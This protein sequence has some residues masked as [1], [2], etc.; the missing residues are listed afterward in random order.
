MAPLRFLLRPFPN[1]ALAAACVF[2]CDSSGSATAPAGTGKELSPGSYFI[3]DFASVEEYFVIQPGH[4]WEFV[5]YGY[6][7]DPKTLCQVARR[8]GVYSSTDST[9]TLIT[10]GWSGWIEKC[11]MTKADFDA[12]PF[13]PPAVP[14]GEAARIRK[15]TADGFEAESLLPGKPAGWMS[16]TKKPDP[17]GF[18]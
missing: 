13:T 18:F 8:R 14:T 6:T 3:R 1:M 4:R 12:Y 2:G 10:K 11:G 7:S 9:L 5:E 17:Y 16:Y 15:V